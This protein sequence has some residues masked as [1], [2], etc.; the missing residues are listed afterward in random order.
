MINYMTK[1]FSSPLFFWDSPTWYVSSPQSSLEDPEWPGFCLVLTEQQVPWPYFAPLS[2]TRWHDKCCLLIFAGSCH[3]EHTSG[4]T[5]H[6]PHIQSIIQ[7][8]SGALT[9]FHL[10]PDGILCEG[11]TCRIC[12][13]KHAHPPHRYSSPSHCPVSWTSTQ[14]HSDKASVVIAVENMWW[15]RE[16]S[17]SQRVNWVA[18]LNLTPAAAHT[19][20]TNY[21]PITEISCCLFVN[22]AVHTFLINSNLWFMMFAVLIAKTLTDSTG[23]S[24]TGR[25]TVYRSLLTSPGFFIQLVLHDHISD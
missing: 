8:P 18:F 17:G 20:V 6:F 12:I 15:R 9:M 4:V 2:G 21:S 14:Q 16:Q 13:R 23:D 24:Q 1:N 19:A 10:I 22:A 3:P 5:F 11:C 25:T 7:H